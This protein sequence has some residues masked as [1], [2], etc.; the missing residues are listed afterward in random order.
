MR[1][2]SVALFV[3]VSEVDEHAHFSQMAGNTRFVITIEGEGAQRYQGIVKCEGDIIA[4]TFNA[5]F[6]QSEQ[7]ATRLW[8]VTDCERAACFLLQ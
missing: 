8:L 4:D 3:H 7:L 2:T 5:Y 1:A 6:T